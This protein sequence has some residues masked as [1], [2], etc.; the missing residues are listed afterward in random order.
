M[1]YDTLRF[2][3]EP[4]AMDVKN[5]A[6]NTPTKKAAL[7]VGVI[8]IVAA[9][10]LIPLGL[11]GYL[12][13]S[14]S[15]STPDTSVLPE[16]TLSSTFNPSASVE[17]STPLFGAFTSV[18][19]FDNNRYASVLGGPSLNEL[20]QQITVYVYQETGATF[21]LQASSTVDTELPLVINRMTMSSDAVHL[22]VGLSNPEA[23]TGAPLKLSLR[24][25]STW[26][27][28]TQAL[29]VTNNE[30]VNFQFD[31][32][33][34]NRC[35][36]SWNILNSTSLEG[37]VRIYEFLDSVWS[38]VGRLANSNARAGDGFGIG[39]AQNG[40]YLVASNMGTLVSSTEYPAQS[41]NYYVRDPES[42]V[43]VLRQ[44]L[45]LPTVSTALGL[46]S[47]G[48]S[49]AVHGNGLWVAVGAPFAAGSSLLEL[50]GGRVF[51]Y[52]RASGDD[53]FAGEPAAVLQS[54]NGKTTDLFGSALRIEGN[55]LFVAGS[56]SQETVKPL[57]YYLL[58]DSAGTVESLGSINGPIQGTSVEGADS[59]AFGYLGFDA[60]IVENTENT[61]KITVG[62]NAVDNAGQ[63]RLLSYVASC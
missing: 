36:V 58:N 19:T 61:F 28:S 1:S 39:L 57:R 56:Y 41:V 21:T 17:G 63:G 33:D 49:V 53:L 50:N 27:A 45:P 23:D 20:K 29:T 55:Y 52:Y 48:F 37:D 31:T 12:T 43:F 3:Y 9:A 44:A 35:F 22:G 24:S 46:N 5:T 10:V 15:S 60:Q 47:F 34:P 59:G 8:L 54:T 26:F 13:P 11:L 38:E 30:P 62:Q 6:L 4:Y 2:K 7:A 51:V 42:N 32:N 18:G 14:S 40:N 16:C 25:G